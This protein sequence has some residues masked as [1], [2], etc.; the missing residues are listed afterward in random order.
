VIGQ[1]KRFEKDFLSSIK[2]FPG[3]RKTLKA[4]GC[5]L[6]L[7]TDCEG[8]PLRH[9]RNILKIDDLLDAIARGRMPGK[10]SQIRN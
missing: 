5:R 4:T 6:G 10:A 1:G 8:A 9:Y 2:P 7:A 3:V